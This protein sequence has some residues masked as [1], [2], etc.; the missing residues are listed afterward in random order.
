MAQ[1][2]ID[3]AVYFPSGATYYNYIT[4][5]HTLDQNTPL[6]KPIEPQIRNLQPLTNYI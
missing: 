1:I 3:F 4:I 5:I 6:I 2:E